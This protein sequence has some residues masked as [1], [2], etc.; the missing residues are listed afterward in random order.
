[1]DKLT[2]FQRSSLMS[3]IRSQNTVPEIA[4]R[5]AVYGL[6]YRYRLHV[7]TLPGTPDIVLPRLNSAIEVRGCFW[8]S[9]GCAK[10][11]VPKSRRWYWVPKLKRNRERD[12]KCIRELRRLGWHVLVVWECEACKPESLLRK[13]ER[14][15]VG[16]D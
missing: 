4:V 8:H 12:R 10:S 3:R 16:P 2:K 7:K 9:H 6:G 11:H 5:Q 13:L 15:L 14:F 1:M